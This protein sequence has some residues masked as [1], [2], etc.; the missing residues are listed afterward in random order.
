MPPE[1]PTAAVVRGH[2][3]YPEQPPF[4]PADSYPEYRGPTSRRAN[5]AYE[6]VRSAL[7]LLYPPGDRFGRGASWNPLQELIE[8]GQTVFIK[9]NLVD[10]EHRY[11]GDIWSVITHP[12]VVRAVADYVALALRGNGRIVIGDNPHVDCNWDELCELYGMDRLAER[13]NEVG[14][15]PVDVV[16]LRSWHMPDLTYYG[17]RCAREA[18][19]GDPNGAHVVDLERSYLDG[20]PWWLFRGTYNERLE[21]IRAH[22]GRHRYPFART[23]WDADTYVSVPKLKSHAKV[24]ATLNI[25]GLIGTIVDKNCLVHW[26]IGYP[27]FGGDEYPTP[28]SWVDYPRLYWQH[29]VTDL[30]PSRVQLAI[31]ERLG[32][33]GVGR[34]YKA[35]VTTDAQRRRL[36]RGAWDGNDT[37]WRMT[38][39]VHDAF[40]GAPGTPAR[41]TLSIIDGVVGGDTD[42]PHFPHRVDAGAIVAAESL[43][44]ADLVAARLMDF[45]IASIAYLATLSQAHDIDPTR[46]DVRGA[47]EHDFFDRDRRYLGYRPPNRWP[48]LSLHDLAPAG[49]FLEDTR[50]ARHAPASTH[51]SAA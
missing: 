16:D 49:D 11:G 7:A 14:G 25:K 37:T 23:I 27:R 45:D 29:A 4:D 15:V 33:T 3:G 2:H 26:S 44:V 8:P 6:G 36:L 18:L 40:V 48:N 31:R 21:T 34:A 19:D 17:W 42:G 9:P 46:I 39:D 24:G 10:H 13:I 22:R 50:R 41:R 51:R 28:A 38:A 12:S 30:V 43:L 1:A 32:R 47:G 20:R 35:A 5:P